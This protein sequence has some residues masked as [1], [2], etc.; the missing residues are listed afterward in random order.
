MTSTI[1]EIIDV[2]AQPD[3]IVS[4]TKTTPIGAVSEL[5]W[6]SFDA[7]ASNVRIIIEENGLGGIDEIRIE[8]DGEGLAP[9]D[10]RQAF[11]FI[12]G[13]WKKNATRTRRLGRIIHG[14]EGKGR[15]K[16]F[17]LGSEVVWETAYRENGDCFTYKISGSIVD[18]RKFKAVRPKKSSSQKTGTTVRVRGISDSLHILLPE[19]SACDRI[20]EQFAMYLKNY[21]GTNLFYG[22]RR[23]DPSLHEKESIFY[24][25]TNIEVEPGKQVSA[26]LHIT[27]WTIKRDRRLYLCDDCGFTLHEAEVGVRPGQEFNFTAYL[28][29]DYL[30]ELN[31]QNQLVLSEL[32]S[33]L[34]VLLDEARSRIR[35]HFREKKSRA[36]AELVK[37]WKNEGVYPYVGEP[38]EATEAAR[39]QVFDILAL[40]VHE[41]IDDFRQGELKSRKLTL[42]L[43]KEALEENPTALQKILDDVL[44]LPKS[45]Q[46][47]LAELLDRTSLSAI[48]ESSRLVADRLTF[49]KGLEELL[50]NTRSKRELL[51]RSQ[52]HRILEDESW[53]FGE[54]FHLTA[55]DETLTTVLRNHLLKLRPGVKIDEVVRD[56]GSK[57]VIDLLLGREIPQNHTTR[58]EF[59]VV[60]LKRPSQKVDLEVKNQLESYALAVVRDERFDLKNTYWTFL[61]ISNE[62][63]EDAELTLTQSG[64]PYGFFLVKDNYKVGLATWAE[65]LQSSRVRLQLFRDKLDITA[66]SDE[67]IALLKTKYSDYIPDSFEESHDHRSSPEFSAPGRPKKR[68]RAVRSKNDNKKKGVRTPKVRGRTKSARK[69]REG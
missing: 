39:R 46:M 51:E 16:A 20:S 5:V 66:T 8:D 56:D 61:A 10:A 44:G 19:G 4:L 3:H 13:S 45:R 31:K 53:I 42:R 24:D 21:P 34:K 41:Y 17:A 15:F 36:A 52:L 29:S 68:N 49:L 54:E 23:I 47:E 7:D 43:L 69:N 35:T 32:H 64:K 38:A 14:K 55:S 62:I 33:G 27:E 28:A 12:G 30:E 65:I 67:G 40:N 57:A 1:P 18:L 22:T 58:R 63:S 60:E 2:T 6:N 59:L 37:Q 11:G 9:S 48:I 26:R 25:I 50:F